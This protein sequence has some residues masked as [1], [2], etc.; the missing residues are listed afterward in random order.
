MNTVAALPGL[1]HQVYKRVLD[2][3]TS[4]KRLAG[5]CQRENSFYVDT[6]RAFRCALRGE[7]LFLQQRLPRSC[8]WGCHALGSRAGKCGHG[9]EGAAACRLCAASHQ[10]RL[11]CCPALRYCRD[12]RYEY[13]GLTKVW[14]GKLDDAKA[15]R[16]GGL[17]RW[18][19]TLLRG[20]LWRLIW[21]EGE[22]GGTLGGR[23][24][25]TCLP[26]RAPACVMP[27][28]CSPLPASCPRPPWPPL[29][30]HPCPQSSG[31]PIRIQEAKDMCVLYDSLQVG[32]VC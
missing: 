4:E 3:P 24:C 23:C 17:R 30:P 11:R 6:V 26:T 25:I 9:R 7:G 18:P 2:K 12:R 13:K 31:N 28:N 20:C 5:I 14:K 15:S 32:G 19:A 8:A 16:A 27:P 10:S 29:T 1:R 21:A 22:L